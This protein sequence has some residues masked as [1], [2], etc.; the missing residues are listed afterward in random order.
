MIFPDTICHVETTNVCLIRL[1]VFHAILPLDP[2][3]H[4]LIQYPFWIFSSTAVRVSLGSRRPEWNNGLCANNLAL[5][6]QHQCAMNNDILMKVYSF[7]TSIYQINMPER[8]DTW[9]VTIRWMWERS[10]R[11]ISFSHRSQKPRCYIY[12]KNRA[13]RYRRLA[14]ATTKMNY[15]SKI[16]LPSCGHDLHTYAA[17]HLTRYLLASLQ[18]STILV[19]HCTANRLWPSRHTRWSCRSMP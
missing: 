1:Q 15:V 5:S 7:D 11:T 14:A 8:Q 13:R 12:G 2:H 10:Q 9:L 19:V 18:G 16:Q 4:Q 6:P 3:S 17:W